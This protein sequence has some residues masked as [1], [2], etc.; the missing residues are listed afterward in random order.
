MEWEEKEKEVE[1]MGDGAVKSNE[2]PIPAPASLFCGWVG[3]V[4]VVRCRVCLCDGLGGLKK[5]KT[6]TKKERQT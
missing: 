1:T 2:R 4:W 5:T 3:L 6:K